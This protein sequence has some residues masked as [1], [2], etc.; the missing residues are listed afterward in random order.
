[1]TNDRGSFVIGNLSF[2]THPGV[3]AHSLPLPLA[4]PTLKDTLTPSDL[5][6]IKTTLTPTDVDDLAAA[7]K[8]CF[9]SSTAVYPLGGGTS[10]AYGTPPKAPGIG[11]SLAGLNRVIDYPARDMT[12]TV[13]AGVTICQLADE[14]AQERQQ[15][16]VDVPQADTATIGGVIATNWNG[17]RRYGLGLLRDYVIGISA[18]DGRGMPFKGGGRVV[19]NVAGYDFCKLLTG[20]MGVLGIISQV[21]LRVRPLPQQSALLA[22]S[23]DDGAEAERLLA[24]INNSPVTPVAVML[25]TGPG[26][27]D[28]PALAAFPPS[29]PEA[30]YVLVRLEGTAPEV[31]WMQQQL[32]DEWQTLGIRRTDFGPFDAL[33]S[34]IIE[35]PAA[36]ESPLVLKANVRPRGVVA[37]VQAARDVDPSCSIL[38]HAGSG[39]VY[40]R[41]PE[42]PKGGL[43]RAL[44]GKLQPAA[45]SLGGSVVI[46]SNPS[47][48]EMT[49]QSVWGGDEG[50]LELMRAVKRNFDPKGILNPGRFV[51]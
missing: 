17:P 48:A 42:F 45:T 3:P 46:L 25:L 49:Q 24:A 2:I 40:V 37:F 34:R 30:F 22:A 36:G 5:L 33:W 20:S 28:D 32:L 21:T 43:S 44:I 9:E 1:M 8:D 41:F 4:H 47:G 11:L 18:V 38:S 27:R 29:S 15:L 12:I 10:L 39:V 16:P 7:V 19:K 50:A 23:V 26:W 31:A 14:L 13:Q 35:W 6:P 51:V